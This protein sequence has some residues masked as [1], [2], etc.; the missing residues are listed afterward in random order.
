MTKSIKIKDLAYIVAS[1]I[2]SK[3]FTFQNRVIISNQLKYFSQNH[4]KLNPLKWDNLIATALRKKRANDIKTNKIIDSFS[5]S[6]R[7]E[8][9]YKQAVNTLKRKTTFK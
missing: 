2:D 1:C 9:V 7:V 5:K 8:N 3:D 4:F 6:N